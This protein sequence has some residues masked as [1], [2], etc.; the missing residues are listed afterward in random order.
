MHMQNAQVRGA[1]QQGLV[2][3][4][5]GYGELQ[6]MKTCQF[7]ALRSTIKMP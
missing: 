3:G 2:V 4:G 5:L 6:S 1:K 7:E